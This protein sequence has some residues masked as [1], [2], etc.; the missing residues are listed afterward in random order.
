MTKAELVKE[1][2]RETG[3]TQAEATAVVDAT[4]KQMAKGTEKDGVLSIQGFGTFKTQMTKERMGRVPS[5][6]EV[7]KISSRKVVKFKAS[8]D[9]LGK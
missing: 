3:I 9:F 2:S 5:T 4:L 7:V 1:V 8:K 6:G